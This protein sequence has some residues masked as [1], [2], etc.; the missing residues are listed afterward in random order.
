MAP[1]LHAKQQLLHILLC[2]SGG[3]DISAA[4]VDYGNSPVVVTFSAGQSVSSNASIPIADDGPGGEGTEQFR[5]SFELPT[6]FSGLQRGT[7][8][9]AVISIDEDAGENMHSTLHTDPI[10]AEV[11]AWWEIPGINTDQASYLHI[12]SGAV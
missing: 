9:E 8:S 12:L 5:A 4:G 10:C 1:L 11:T 6:G 7:P 3:A 2:C